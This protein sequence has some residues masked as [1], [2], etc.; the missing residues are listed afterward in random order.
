MPPQSLAPEEN[1]PGPCSDGRLARPANGPCGDGRLARPAEAKQG[2]ILPAVGF[3]TANP[4]LRKHL[5]RHHHA[6]HR[7]PFLRC[8]QRQ[9]DLRPHRPPRWP[10]DSLRHLQPLLPRRSGTNPLKPNSTQ[11]RISAS[12]F[13]KRFPVFLCVPLCSPWSKT[14]C[15]AAEFGNNRQLNCKNLQFPISE[16]PQNSRARNLA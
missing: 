13:V 12:N 8:P 11:C 3:P 16:Q 14:A 5:P 7:R 6:I 10:P 9:K 1:H 2:G 15:R 4:N